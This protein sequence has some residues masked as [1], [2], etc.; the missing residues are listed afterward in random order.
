MMSMVHKAASVA[1]MACVIVSL[2]CPASAQTRLGDFEREVDRL[3]REL[4]ALK[5]RYID[6]KLLEQN[7]QIENRINEGR[8][9]YLLKD[10]TR[11]S[12]IFVDLVYRDDIRGT[13][14]H[15]DSLF[16]LGDSLF[17]SKNYVGARRHFNEL[18]AVGSGGYY[19]DT[20]RRLIEIA[21]ETEDYEGV[22]RLYQDAR[23]RGAKPELIYI[24]GKSLFFRERNQEA[25]STFR[26]ISESSDLIVL[27]KE[28][29]VDVAVFQG[30]Q[31]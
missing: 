28:L 16:Y 21:I 8:V 4:L 6:P 24:Y 18:L 10:Y 27:F 29:G 22:E 23:A 9:F 13:P 14:A 31:L 12:I 19:Q 1:L 20:V 3:S 17:L 26:E 2:V 11:A 15:R 30:E 7:Y 5:N 25:V